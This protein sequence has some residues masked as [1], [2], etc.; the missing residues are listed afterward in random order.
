MVEN[1][2]A[3]LPFSCQQVFDL[4]ADIER[5]PEFL[6]GWVAARITRR[7]G[8][9]WQVAQTMGVGPMRLT[10]NST[11]VLA[12]PQRIDVTSTEYPFKQYSLSWLM[13][14]LATGGCRI[15]IVAEFEFRSRFLQGVANSVAPAAIADTL[16]A[17][18]RRAHRLYDAPAA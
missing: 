4:A 17:F 2:S 13:S 16:T 11:A 6:N 15:G 18:E 5:Y 12:A 7:D 9:V 14:A 1:V 10:F 8:N 3:I